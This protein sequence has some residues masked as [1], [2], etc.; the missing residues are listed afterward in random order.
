MTR[1]AVVVGAGVLGACTALELLDRGWSVDVVDRGD[2]GTPSRADTRILRFSHGADEWLTR[3]AVAGIRGWHDLE[4]RS[5]A[6]FIETRGVLVLAGDRAPGDWE[7]DSVAQVRR[8]GVPVRELDPAATARRFPYL[9]P[10]GLAFAVWEPTAGVIRAGEALRA[11]HELLAGHGGKVHRAGCRP[12][13]DDTVLV[14]GTPL[15]ADAVIWAVGA[16]AGQLF[17]GRVRIRAA[18]Q[19]SYRLA[20]D[21]AADTRPAWLDVGAELYGIP[22]AP[23]RTTKVVLDVEATTAPA[24]G[25]LPSRLDEYL[26]RRFPDLD[27]TV[28]DQ[29]RCTYAATDDDVPVLGRL[30][31]T[32]THWLIGGDGGIAFKHA[33]AWAGIL[34][35]ALDGRRAPPRR[36]AVDR[37]SPKGP[38]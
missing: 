5:G 1:R 6:G 25:L 18:H 35:D 4:R 11:L 19:D 21:P 3:S 29:E 20:G 23:G 27:H 10:R 24:P 7:R 17:P 38:A 14:D 33:P 31:G 22:G 16:Q 26:H 8:C 30:P 28:R 12:G 36:L 34:A 37:P 32:G 2:P 9:D 15:G 13:P